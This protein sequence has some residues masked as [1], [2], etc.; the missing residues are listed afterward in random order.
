MVSEAALR[1]RVAILGAGPAGMVLGNILLQNGIDCM[2]VDSHS[3]EDIYARGRA[4]LIESTAIAQLKR[5]ALADSIFKNGSAHGRCEF[6]FPDFSVILEYAQW[7]G[8]DAHYVYPQNDFVN[9]MQQLYLDRGGVVRFAAPARAVEQGADGI[10]VHCVELASGAALRIDAEFVIGCDGFHGLARQC[11]PTGAGRAYHKQHAYGWLAVLAYAAPS[12]EHIIYALHPDGF[13]GHMLRTDKVSRYYLQVPLEEDVANWPDERVWAS[14]RRRLAKRGWS[15]TEGEIFEKR[16]LAMRS[17]V[18]EPMRYG[19][20]FLAGDAAHIITPC[21]AKGMNLA[22]QDVVLLGE[23]LLEYC[24]GARDADSLD[25]YSAR[26]L[27]MIWR[28][29]EFS[30]A[31]LHMLHKP[32]I[33][34]PQE[35]SF[36]QKLNESKLAQLVSSETFRRDFSRNYVGIV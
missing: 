7:A 9:D 2:V 32:A 16:V 5:H 30:H 33:T 34:D 25:E 15:L 8:G 23:L 36:M 29:Q 10:R 35:A 3:R 18:Q 21:G 13:A 12:T 31:M 1:T 26:R 20:L 19:R 24:R 4:G 6:R 11:V 17:Y 14:L 22:V 27:P 28:A